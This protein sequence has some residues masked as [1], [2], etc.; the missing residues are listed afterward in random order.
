MDNQILKINRSDLKQLDNSTRVARYFSYN[1]L[2]DFVNNQLYFCNCELFD[3]NNERKR[4][5]RGKYKNNVALNIA[6]KINEDLMN[7]CSVYV[8]CWT[9]YDSE[10]VALWKIYDKEN[11]GACVITTV[12][13]LKEQLNSNILIGKVIYDEFANIPWLDIEGVASNYIASEF[14]KIEPYFFEKEIRAVFFS[15]SKVRGIVKEINFETL[16]DYVV[17]SP[18]ANSKNIQKIKEL[19]S[20]KFTNEK[21]KLSIISENPK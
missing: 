12:G 17:L 9:L 14:V 8:S 11:T 10:N 5:D 3:D 16:V 4:I 20:K 1:R 7:K 18:F 21:I 15:K 2:K 19:F 6:K 13:K